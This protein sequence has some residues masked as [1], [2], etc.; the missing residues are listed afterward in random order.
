MKGWIFIRVLLKLVP[1]ILI[2]LLAL[3]LY[4]YLRSAR[5]EENELNVQHDLIIQRVED[6]GKLELVKYHFKEITELEKLSKKYFKIFQLGPDSKM[7]L[8]T[9]GEAV[10]CIDLTKMKREDIFIDDDAVIVTLPKPELCYYKIDLQKSRIYSLETNPL[11][12]EKKFIEEAYRSAEEQIKQSALNAGI[13]YETEENAEKVLRP[14]FEQISGKKV[15]FRY[16]MEG[17][18][19]DDL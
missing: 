17:K 10:G 16:K 18:P 3:W 2:V 1:Y 13:L 5:E 14:I 12:D 7:A 4:D 9:T 19:I 15:Y 11:I 8:I 6:L